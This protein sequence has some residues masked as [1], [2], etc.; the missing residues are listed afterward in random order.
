MT[1]TAPPAILL[2]QQSSS[3]LLLL[4]LLHKQ[5]GWGKGQM[6][7][8]QQV[9]LVPNLNI[10][11]SYYNAQQSQAP[12]QLMKYHNKANTTASKRRKSLHTLKS[13]N[14]YIKYTESVFNV[15]PTK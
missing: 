12:Q 10:Q 5:R 4:E 11:H 3:T 8:N 1:K 15:Q 13:L 14:I 6:L 7:Q 9:F 2:D